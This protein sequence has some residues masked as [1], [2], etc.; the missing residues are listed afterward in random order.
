MPG[1][2]T[3]AATSTHLLGHC[4]TGQASCITICL[5][6]F[7]HCFAVVSHTGRDRALTPHET[8]GPH[9]QL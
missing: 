2:F 7:T 9:G 1:L 3:F 8:D 6:W 5:R 4:C